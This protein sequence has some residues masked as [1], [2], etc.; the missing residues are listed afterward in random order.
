MN[1]LNSDLTILE[2]HSL[3]DVWYIAISF[4]EDNNFWFKS[5][6]PNKYPDKEIWYSTKLELYLIIV[7]KVTMG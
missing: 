4:G 5:I 3:D 6:D 2:R 7:D 1:I